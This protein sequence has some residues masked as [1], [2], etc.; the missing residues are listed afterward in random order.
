MTTRR[1]VWLVAQREIRQRGRS[2]VF[3]FSSAAIVLGIV[4]LV[5][6]PSII[7]GREE[8]RSVGLVGP[9]PAALSA[10]LRA[11]AASTDSAIEVLRYRDIAYGEAALR[12]K[13][14]EV[15]VVDGTELVWLGDADPRLSALVTVAT[16]A[17]DRLQR[18]V[19]LG[20]TQTQ[21]QELLTP[22]TLASRSLEPTDPA[23]GI[24]EG[25]VIVGVILIYLAIALYG[26][27]VVSGVVE[28]KTSRVV[29]VL[30]SRIRPYRL[31]A[32]TVLGIGTLGLV[33]LACAG[34]AALVTRAIVGSV[35][36]ASVDVGLVASLLLWFVLGFSLYSVLNAG[37]GAL[38]SRQEDAQGVS[39]PIT[40]FGIVGYLIAITATQSPTSALTI[41]ASFF[42]FTAPFVMPVRV[43][44]S[45]VPAWQIVTAAALTAGTIY[46]VIRIAGRVYSGAVLSVGPRMKLA[47]AWHSG[48][49]RAS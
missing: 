24:R 20:L 25:A 32:G 49:E 31:V 2:R 5:A 42:P 22:R 38:A 3:L 30:L 15:L 4:L 12:S 36:L 6:L 17:A 29:E 19:E 18:A 1:T 33:Q 34:A 21:A 27:F 28:E 47:E 16:Q 44:L 43:A 11:S 35:D 8:V 14:V 7:A 26:S 37:A 10:T 45:Y 46:L 41:V 48:A 40:I 23:R 13:N 39:A 9:A